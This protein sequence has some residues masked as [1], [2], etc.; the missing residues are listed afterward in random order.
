MENKSTTQA[1]FDDIQLQILHEI[2]KAR[3]SVHIAVAWFTD[4][5]IFGLLCEKAAAGVR[6]ELLITKDSINRNSPLDYQQLV[7]AGGM[8]LM[9][10][11]KKRRSTIMH[12]KFCVIDAATVING[13]YNWSKSARENWENIVVIR[14]APQVAAQYI[15]E[16]ENILNH[17]AG[18]ADG[19]VDYAKISARLE[20]LRHFLE[21][22]DDDDI[23]LQVA[24][25]EKIIPPDD[26]AFEEPLAII[27]TI[28]NGDYSGA[29]NRLNRYVSTHKQVTTYI[30]PEIPVLKMELS[31]L[32]IQIET[33]QAEKADA[34]KVLLNY[35]YRYNIELGE[36]VRKVLKLRAEKLRAEAEESPEKQTAYQEAQQDA[37]SF[38]QD[39]A[40]SM[41]HQQFRI[42][43]AEQQE[44]KAL[45]RACS[46]MCHPDM[47]AE[48]QKE[49]ASLMQAQLNEAYAQND[50][51]TVKQLHDQI[52]AGIFT[53]INASVSDAQKMYQQVV[54]LRGKV[55]ELSVAIY[56]LRSSAQY[57]KIAAIEQMDEH[58]TTLKQQLETELTYLD[59][60]DG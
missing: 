59:S 13:S 22:E 3:T 9:V 17:E 29:L 23:A 24:K 34:E 54:T 20:A 31:A 44:L 4:T 58:F 42:S 43:E 46:K 51:E 47:V 57:R 15:E 36:L 49:Q 10:G 12:N 1:F 14:N 56:E 35:H 5:E 26:P 33:L 25:L 30:D 19:K 50:M 11:D 6:V 7:D 41:Q 45:F 40:H 18:K 39:F 28:E 8:F 2:G 32:E 38:E 60:T 55:K 16:F 53:P 48:G 37:E 27:N 52:K 21:L